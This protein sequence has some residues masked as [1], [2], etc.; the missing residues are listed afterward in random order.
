MELEILEHTPLKVG[1]VFGQ[2]EIESTHSRLEITRDSMLKMKIA[3]TG[4]GLKTTF[5]D[6]VV[7][8]Q[9]TEMTVE[10][11]L[12]KWLENFTIKRE[13][14]I[15]GYPLDINELSR[16][17]LDNYPQQWCNFENTYGYYPF[18]NDHFNPVL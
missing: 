11:T 9:D 6:Y 16:M 14:I 18:K 4:V 5:H 7:Y 12:Y 10:D 13:F 15:M 2:W 8:S 1:S 17:I 3:Q